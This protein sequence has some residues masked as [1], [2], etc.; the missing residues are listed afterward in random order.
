MIRG[1]GIDIVAIERIAYMV[2]R[3]QDQFLRRVFTPVE[4]AYCREKAAPEI[5]YAGRWAAK[6]AFYKA[7]PVVLQP[8]ATWKS[9]EIIPEQGSGKPVIAVCSQEITAKFVAWG[10]TMTHLS[11]SHERQ[12]CTAVVIIE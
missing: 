4:I 1:L 10:V 9:V 7:L 8:Y 3:Y 11:L 5:H 2:E 12:M 6:E